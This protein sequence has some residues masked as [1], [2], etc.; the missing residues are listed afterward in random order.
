MFVTTVMVRVVPDRVEDF[1]KATLVNHRASVEE[2]GN[3]RFDVLQNEQEPT[4]FLL[5]EAYRSE[6]DASAHKNTSHY[7]LWR[8]TV[9]VWMAEPRKGITYKGLNR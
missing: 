7:R 2:P 1:I 3:I 5:Y 9:A 8:D 4:R 6:K